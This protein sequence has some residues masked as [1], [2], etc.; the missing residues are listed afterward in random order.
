MESKNFVLVLGL[1]E[2]QPGGPRVNDRSEVG[3]LFAGGWQAAFGSLGSP[4][5]AGL[6]EL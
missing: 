5:S 6:M 1:H 3:G 2:G 4:V